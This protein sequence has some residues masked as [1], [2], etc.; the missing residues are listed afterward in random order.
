MLRLFDYMAEK[1]YVVAERKIG[2]MNPS[3]ENLFYQKATSEYLNYKNK[4]SDAL[5]KIEQKIDILLADVNNMP[6]SSI[7][8]IKDIE[9]LQREKIDKERMMKKIDY[10]INETYQTYMSWFVFI[11][12]ILVPLIAL[13]ICWS[14]YAY[15]DFNK[16][17]KA[18]EFIDE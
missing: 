12:V 10:Q 4:I 18:K 9:E 6:L 8:K 15:Y 5:L 13:A 16:K 11:A 1:K 17:L 14:I 3:I 2:Y 7:T